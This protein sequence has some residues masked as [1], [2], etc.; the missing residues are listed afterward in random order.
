[1]PDRFEAAHLRTARHCREQAARMR[2]QA[3]TVA[4][5]KLRRLMLQ[6]AELYDRLAQWAERWQGQQKG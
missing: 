2:K 1:M 4:G 6:N 5:G 3:N